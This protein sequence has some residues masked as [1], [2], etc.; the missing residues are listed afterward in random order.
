VTA[1]A[2]DLARRFREHVLQ[3]GQLEH[4]DKV[5]VALSGGLDSVA[6]L[7]LFRFT[8][9]L[10]DIDLVAAHLDHRMR[11]ES[12]GDAEWA[13]GLSRA[14]GVPLCTRAVD[15]PP[16]SEEEARLLRYD[17][18]E[19]VRT[20]EGARWVVTAHHADDQV[21]TVLFR[22]A[23]GT[24]LRGLRGIPEYRTP[25]IWRPLLPFSRSDIE[26]YASSSGL[27]WREDATNAGSAFAR[28]VLRHQVIPVLEAQVAPGAR[29][30]VLRLAR[31]ARQE[32]D[33]WE[34]LLPSL[35]AS[36][37][38]D[39]GGGQISFRRE[40]FL[41]YHGAVRARV[42]RTLARQLGGQLDAAGTRIAVEFTS[43]GESGR[44]V[45]LT[46]SLDL[47]R[48]LDRIILSPSEAT[49]SADRLLSIAGG[50]GM[51]EAVLGGARYEVRWGPDENWGEWTDSFDAAGVRGP[52]TLRAWVPGDRIRLSYGSKKLKK[53]FLESRLPRS[54]RDRTPVLVDAREQVLWVPGLVRSALARPSG[55]NRE[56]KIGVT[57]AKTD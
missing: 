23:R 24:G 48:D 14:W 41:E 10:P 43:S 27:R 7:H 53:V 16:T 54:H 20:R 44:A 6:L 22:I 51:G 37:A 56:L 11:D 19:E 57:H 38:V 50:E 28:N 12:G 25:G 31:L 34:S 42:L 46:G 1:A 5:V 36:L 26:G 52:L 30:A 18:F 32:E 47:K 3:G 45:R 49:P 13:A 2:H 35:I 29:D 55:S 4:G 33:A 39:H 8:S 15:S 40:A 17:F 9:G 21:E